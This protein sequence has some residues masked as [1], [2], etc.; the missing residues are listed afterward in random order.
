LLDQNTIGIIKQSTFE[1]Q[2]STV[3]FKSM[4]QYNVCVLKRVTR[5]TPLQ[6]FGQPTIK[7]DHSQFLKLFLPFFGFTKKEI[8]LRIHPH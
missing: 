5:A 6:F 4:D 7:N 8:N 1:K 2:K 3:F